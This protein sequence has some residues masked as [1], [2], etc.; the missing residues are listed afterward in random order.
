MKK[1]ILLWSILLLFTVC[2]VAKEQDAKTFLCGNWY[3]KQNMSDASIHTYNW[4]KGKCVIN[5]TLEINLYG[6][7]SELF[8]PLI[9]GPFPITEVKDIDNNTISFTFFFDRGGFYVTYLIHK[10]DNGAIWFDFQK[11]ESSDL[12]PNFYNNGEKF[13]WYKIAGPEMN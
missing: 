3:R 5:F 12:I 13:L 2:G 7:K 4:G 6:D 10:L 8:I 11:G 9:G 1:I